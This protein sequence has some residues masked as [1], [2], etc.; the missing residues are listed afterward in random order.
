[1]DQVSLFVERALG[2][3]VISISPVGGGSISTA[4]KVTL[5]GRRPV[6]VKVSPQQPGMFQK[7]ANGLRALAQAGAIK[8]PE[9]MFADEHILILEFLAT[10]PPSNRKK[11]FEIFG[12]QCAGLHRCTAASF[13]FTEDNYIGSTPQQNTPRT[14]SWKEFY[15]IRRLQFQYYLAERNGY[16]DSQLRALFAALTSRI[17]RLIPDDGEP[18]ALL[19]GDLWN[20][21]VL[22]LGGETTAIIDPAV[23]YGHREADLAMTMLFGGFGDSFYSAY[24]EVYPLRPGWQKRM[25]LYKLYHLFNHLNIFGEGYY[26]QV[27]GTMQRLVE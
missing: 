7:E 5:A 17:D 24:H 13:G 21:N 6:F 3:R 2:K 1:M 20:G 10:S 12:R 4:M 25:E 14:D 26:G 19:H 9:V 18:P 8:V 27:V 16:C 22:I 23:Y 15:H 11:T